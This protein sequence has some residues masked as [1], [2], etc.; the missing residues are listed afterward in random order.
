M[1]K[2]ESVPVSTGRMRSSPAPVS[3]FF[4]GSSV[5]EPSSDRLYCMKTKFQ[6]ST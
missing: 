4:L 5:M 2:M 6:I 3:M 1:S